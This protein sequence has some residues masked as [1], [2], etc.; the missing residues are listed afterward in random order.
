[1]STASYPARASRAKVVHR[2]TDLL[3]LEAQWA[4]ELE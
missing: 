3:R 4:I 2:V 1:M